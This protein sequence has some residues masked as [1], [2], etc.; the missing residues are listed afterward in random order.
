MPNDIQVFT[1]PT[2]V[3]SKLLSDNQM[4]SVDGEAIQIVI[5]AVCNWGFG[6]GV[7]VG[8]AVVVIAS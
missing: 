4:R 7:A 2:P 1:D 5:A 8:I 6:L 3:S